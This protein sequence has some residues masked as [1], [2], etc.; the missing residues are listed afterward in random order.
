MPAEFWH[1]GAMFLR[2]CPF[3][4][5]AL[6]A[7]AEPPSHAKI[8]RGFPR[9]RRKKPS[10]RVRFGAGFRLELMAAEPL[11]V[12]PVAMAFDENGRLFVVEM[13]DYPERSAE[14][15]GR[16]KLLEDTDGDGRFDRATVFA[17]G[18]PW[19]TGITCWDGGVFVLASP[20]LLYFKDMD[21]DGRADVHALIFTGFGSLAAR[22]NV[23]ALPNSLQWGPDQ[24]IH[25]ALG[26]D[27]SLVQ[28]FAR[29]NVPKV[30]LRGR[31]FSFDPRLMDLRA[32]SGGGQFG[33]SFDDA[34]R[35]FVSA[36][37]RHLMQV[38]FEDSVATRSPAIRCPRRPSTSP[39]MAR[40]RRSSARSPDEPWRV[41]RTQWR[42]AATCAGRWKAA[43]GRAAISLARAVRP[44][45]A[46]TRGRPNFTATFSSRTAGAI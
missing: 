17:E 7:A 5:S 8:S 20:E 34:G 42:V 28:N 10:R 22:R 6:L 18:L 4:F 36:N 23:Q 31:D 40:R 2:C 14:K 30:E 11:I 43:G 45:F 24:R 41:L 13:R 38:M 15:L 21:G 26:G 35:K 33:L 46:E 44:S 25:G 12:D 37:S 9:P 29:P 39:R 16:V 1:K 3:F 32:E 19:P 27:A